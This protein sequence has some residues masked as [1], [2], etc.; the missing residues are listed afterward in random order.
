MSESEIGSVVRR[1]EYVVSNVKKS[2]DRVGVRERRAFTLEK[3]E[4]VFF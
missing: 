3:S 2:V 4:I 1:W